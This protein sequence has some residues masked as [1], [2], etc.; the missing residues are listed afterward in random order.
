MPISQQDQFS[1]ADV[2]QIADEA[3]VKSERF[4]AVITELNQ[5]ILGCLVTMVQVDREE[6]ARRF[7]IRDEHILNLLAGLDP[8]DILA[9]APG[10]NPLAKLEV[11]LEVLRVFEDRTFSPA[12]NLRMAMESIKNTL[13]ADLEPQQSNPRRPRTHA[14]ASIR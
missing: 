1:I 4:S 10:T 14:T 5:R 6:T 11:D 9:I 7:G 12:N 13:V 2:E 8:N 3:L